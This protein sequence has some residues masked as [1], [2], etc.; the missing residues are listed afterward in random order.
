[1]IRC[2]ALLFYRLNYAGKPATGL[3]PAT[4]GWEKYPDHFTTEVLSVYPLWNCGDPDGA[5]TRDLR[6]DKAMRLPTALQGRK[7]FSEKQDGD[8]RF[9]WKE[10]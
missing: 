4:R 7:A 6:R 8:R 3:E 9:T 1:M 5:R 10:K 2:L